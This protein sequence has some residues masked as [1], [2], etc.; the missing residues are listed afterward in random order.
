MNFS[1]P[2][3]WQRDSDRL[4]IHWSGVRIQLMNYRQKEGWFLVPSD[5]D[6][7]VVGF[8]PNPD[9]RDKAFATFARGES[10]YTGGVRK[11]KPEAKREEEPEEPDEEDQ[12]AE[13]EKDDKEG[14]L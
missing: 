3:G 9:G 1:A 14:D 6:R 2:E 11:P 4:Y 8:D 10:T 5:L 7:P 13:D 12:E